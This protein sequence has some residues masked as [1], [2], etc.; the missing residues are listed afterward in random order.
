MDKNEQR[1]CGY[2]ALLIALMMSLPRLL[3]LREHGI[4]ARYWHF[5]P[6]EFV[7]QFVFNLLFCYLLFNINLRS[8]SVLSIYRSDN[9]YATY[10]LFNGSVVLLGITLGSIIQFICFESARLGVLWMGY[11]AR[12]GLSAVMMGIIVKIILLLRQA[13]NKDI[14]NEQLKSARMV[15]ELDLLKEQ[16]N[17]HFLFNSLSSLSGVIREDPELAQKYLR[18]LSN[19]FR[20]ALARSKANLV[21]LDEELAMLRSFAQLITMRLEDAFKLDIEV[22]DQFMACQLPHL[23]LQPLL[24]NAVKHN[25]ATKRHPLKVKIYVDDEQLVMVNT[26]NE[27]EVPEES[28]GIGLANLN[29]RFKI[30][31]DHE[32][33]I[34]KTDEY[35]IVKL[36]LKT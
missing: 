1:I 23:S 35:F 31:L 32:I 14:E 29:E 6:A 19:V 3:A 17:P 4:I 25:S 8:N 15:A 27:I 2:S 21:R 30:M 12:F 7:F 13:R 22:D 5:N 26:L 34:V 18:E 11:L 20:Y 28:N 10:F 9:R 24:E 16:M 33:G 36:P